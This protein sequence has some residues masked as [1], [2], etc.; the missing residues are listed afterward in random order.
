MCHNEREN[1]SA[2]QLLDF[3]PASVMLAFVAPL[4]NGFRSGCFVRLT[5]APPA[6]TVLDW[7]E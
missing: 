2:K 5:A 7:S 3:L 1:I 4:K 6:E